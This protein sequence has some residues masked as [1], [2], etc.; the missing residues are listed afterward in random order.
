MRPAVTVR[1]LGVMSPIHMALC[2]D[3]L[4]DPD[5]GCWKCRGQIVVP[6]EESDA[7]LILRLNA[8][9]EGVFG[10]GYAMEQTP[11]LLSW[12]KEVTG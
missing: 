10:L 5:L 8:N 6:C 7:D 12:L 3:C 1:D 2:K 4:S 11:R 9:T